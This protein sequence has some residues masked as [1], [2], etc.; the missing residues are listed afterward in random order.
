MDGQDFQPGETYNIGGKD[1]K[2]EK[3]GDNFKLSLAE[4]LLNEA[5]DIFKNV[6]KV[7]NRH[8][9]L[10]KE[11]E[12]KKSKVYDFLYSDE[13]Q[14]Y[15]GVTSFTTC[16]G[17]DWDKVKEYINGKGIDGVT[18][19]QVFLNRNEDVTEEEFDKYYEEW[20][21]YIEDERNMESM[22]QQDMNW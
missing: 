20:L 4:G 5:E 8:R 18:G 9:R 17:E 16:D 21:D 14:Q 7:L 3:Q 1:Y 6:D 15:T 19:K 11:D 13:I 10:L 12:A 2:V 22:N